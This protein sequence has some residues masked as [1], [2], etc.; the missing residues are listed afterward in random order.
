MQ[1]NRSA[2]PATISPVLIY[3]DVR[4]AVALLEAAFGFGERVRIG[5]DHR[6]QMRAGDDGS[7][8][9]ADVRHDQV[10]PSGGV[11]TQ[12]IKFRVP[13]VDAA[14]ARAKRRG[15]ARARGAADARLRRALVRRRGSRRPP[16]G[17]DADGARR[18]PRG[19]GRHRGRALVGD[20]DS[21][22]RDAAGERL[23]DDAVALGQL[24]QLRDRL[25]VLV[26]LEL[27]AKPDRA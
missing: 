18:R 2:P 4:A 8:V 20:Y 12:L 17:A 11:V 10:A 25:V 1:T 22:D 15:R 24:E 3:P 21:V 27:E 23:E 5:D 6:A 9:V 14:F 13:D 7:F 16:L 26:V 19:M